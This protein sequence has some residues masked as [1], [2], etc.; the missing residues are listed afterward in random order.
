MLSVPT[1]PVEGWATIEG[2][3]TS[4]AG[5]FQLQTLIQDEM[6]GTS[7]IVIHYT[8]PP[9]TWPQQAVRIVMWGVRESHFLGFDIPHRD[10]FDGAGPAVAG[11]LSV[12]DDN[13]FVSTFLHGASASRPD[14]P[15][16]RGQRQARH[17]QITIDELGRWDMLAEQCVVESFV[18]SAERVHRSSHRFTDA[19]FVVEAANRELGPVSGL[20]MNRV[21]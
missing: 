5:D 1:R 13:A 2:T 21:D 12:S 9:L 8:V 15:S 4:V 20:G 19:R 3:G 18:L 7:M 17:W 10:S 16:T 14:R 6:S 11:A